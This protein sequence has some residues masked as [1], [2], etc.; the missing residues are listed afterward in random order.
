M[1]DLQKIQENVKKLLQKYPQFASLKHRKELI[2]IY[3]KEFEGLKFG[4]TKEMWFY[5]LTNSE[6][7]SRAIRKCQEENPELRASEE[8]E[9]GRYEQA[10]EYAKFYQKNTE[11]LKAQLKKQK[12]KIEQQIA[13]L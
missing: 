3:Y 12:K 7:I 13:L 10:G 2:W 11:K 8:E 5:R 6:T 1:P 9:K 4:I